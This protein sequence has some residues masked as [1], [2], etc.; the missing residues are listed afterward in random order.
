[1]QIC[2][3]RGEFEGL[4][5]GKREIVVWYKYGIIIR[6]IMLVQSTQLLNIYF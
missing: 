5:E 3:G 4:L 6:I 1:M 2:V